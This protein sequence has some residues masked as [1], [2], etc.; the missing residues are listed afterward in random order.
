MTFK[1]IR[2]TFIPL[3]LMTTTPFLTVLAWLIAVKYDGSIATF[4]SLV[5]W[6]R[7]LSEW[8]LPTW[9]A[10]SYLGGFAILQA[11]L[12]VVLPGRDFQ[13][14]VTPMGNRPSY[15]L[16]GV[17]SFLATFVLLFGVLWPMGR[18]DPAGVWLEYGSLLSTLVTFAFA[19]CA[20]L[21]LKGRM[22]PSTTD[23]GTS[24]NFLF[25]FYWG[26]EL[27]PQLSRR[28]N[29][30]QFVNCRIAMMGWAVLVACMVIAQKDLPLGR[31]GTAILVSAIL[32]LTYIFKFFI[33]EDGYFGSLDIMHD[34]FGFYIC[35]GILAWLPGIYPVAT[36]YLVPK[37]Y[38]LPVLAAIGILAL[39]W[40]AI[41]ANYDADA[42]RLRVR[43][44]DGKTTVWGRPPV[45]MTA[46]WTS[47]DGTPRQSL[48]L[49]SGWWG[50]ARHV[51]YVTEILLALAWTLPAGFDN[52]LP[53]FYVTFLTILLTHRSFRDEA[54]CAAKYG[55]DWV[56]YKKKVPWRIIPGIF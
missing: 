51:H 4:S 25:D 41:W 47:G 1:S 36:I 45:L 27:H 22:A 18:F 12:L 44:T 15:K 30:K 19:F 16:N 14:P 46:R 21:Y 55:E 2:R 39:G 5:T 28:L 48:L 42:Q 43:R 32:Q 53:Y 24:G 20:F 7:L 52:Y 9:K 40:F 33:W 8:P 34:R 31:P 11:I 38:D 54:R 17:A 29:L 26:V 23:A 37:A 50:Q 13:G 10:A 49:V 35:W 6:D 56:E 3:F